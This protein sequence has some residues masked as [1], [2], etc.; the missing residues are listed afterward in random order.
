MIKFLLIFL[1]LIGETRYLLSG[2]KGSEQKETLNEEAI[3]V[4]KEKAKTPYEVRAMHQK[5]LSK[6]TG[7]ERLQ[8]MNQQEEFRKNKVEQATKIEEDKGFQKD[9]NA[10]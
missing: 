4:A 8:V 9:L 5:I 2:D 7:E 6:R 10:Q 3:R 1:F